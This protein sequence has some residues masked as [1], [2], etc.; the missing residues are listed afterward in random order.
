MYS[1]KPAKKYL[2]QG[3]LNANGT[4]ELSS[5]RSLLQAVDCSSP[6]SRVQAPRE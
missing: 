3:R 1:E 5:R 6:L 2:Y 4:L